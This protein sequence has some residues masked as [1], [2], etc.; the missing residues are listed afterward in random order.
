[1]KNLDLDCDT[2]EKVA[3]ILRA[4][5]QAYYE[6]NGELESAWQDKQAG[7]IWSKIARILEQAADKIDKLD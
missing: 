3:P 2:P 4:A 1:M 7:K 6:S 5:A